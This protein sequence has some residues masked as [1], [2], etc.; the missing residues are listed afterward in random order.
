MEIDLVMVDMAL[1][2]DHMQEVDHMLDQEQE[3]MVV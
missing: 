3:V 2:V 1:A